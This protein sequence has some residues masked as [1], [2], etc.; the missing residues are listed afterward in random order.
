MQLNCHNC[1]TEVETATV[2]GLL[3]FRL[4]PHRHANLYAQCQQCGWCSQ[5][6]DGKPQGDLV[7]GDVHDA[8]DHIQ[9]LIDQFGHG[10]TVELEKLNTVEDARHAYKIIKN[11]VK[12]ELSEKKQ[13]E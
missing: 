4:K 5:L 11:I 8:R 2:S 6:I 13:E 3:A 9:A 1:N 10:S 12:F 7:C